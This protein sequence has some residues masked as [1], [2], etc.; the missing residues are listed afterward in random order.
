[1]IEVDGGQT[2][3]N[4]A[5]A[6]DA[7]ADVIVAGSAVFGSDDYAAAIARIRESA[8]RAKACAR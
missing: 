8:L 7:G 4:A 1:M 2:S 5:L 6:V 3:E